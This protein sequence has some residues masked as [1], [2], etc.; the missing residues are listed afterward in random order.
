MNQSPVVG[1]TI[2][3]ADKTSYPVSEKSEVP[4][5]RI[6]SPAY[7]AKRCLQILNI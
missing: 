6:V 3:P 5:R 4:T 1:L 2:G 7:T